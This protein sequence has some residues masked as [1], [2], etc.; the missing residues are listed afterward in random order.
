MTKGHNLDTPACNGR[1]LRT[2]LVSASEAERSFM[3]V[4]SRIKASITSCMSLVQLP[5]FGT[6]WRADMPRAL[7][8]ALNEALS[9]KVVHTATLLPGNSE[10]TC[11]KTSKPQDSEQS[12]NSLTEGGKCISRVM[13]PGRIVSHNLRAV[14][15]SRATWRLVS[16][17]SLRENK[18]AC[19]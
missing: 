7:D 4:A 18:S 9:N 17:S 19:R 3:S 6:I 15:R 1:F 10:R 2:A 8:F 16:P 13:N 12:C 5:A 11:L 14:S